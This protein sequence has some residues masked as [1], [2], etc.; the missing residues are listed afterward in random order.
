MLYITDP[1]PNVMKRFTDLIY[2]CS[3]LFSV[4]PWKAFPAYSNIYE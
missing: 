4:C 3:E 1:E 2:K